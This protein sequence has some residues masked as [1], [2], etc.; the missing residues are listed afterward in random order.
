MHAN[1][2]LVKARKNRASVR[3]ALSPLHHQLQARIKTLNPKSPTLRDSK[4]FYFRV[5]GA[6]LKV[7]GQF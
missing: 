5:F 4:E 2:E 3:T 7:F 1:K 6:F